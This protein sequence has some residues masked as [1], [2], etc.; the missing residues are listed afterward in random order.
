MQSSN[1]QPTKS[2]LEYAQQM[3]NTL[4]DK[5]QSGLLELHIKFDVEES[6][7]LVVN[8]FSD[9]GD[10]SILLVPAGVHEVD[11]SNLL[12]VNHIIGLNTD[13]SDF[14]V[15]KIIAND[16]D[17][18]NFD[19]GQTVELA[20]ADTQCVHANIRLEAD[21]NTVLE[22]T[23]FEDKQFSD[24]FFNVQLA[25]NVDILNIYTGV[26]YH[27]RDWA[28]NA[29]GH[30]YRGRNSLEKTLDNA[31]QGVLNAIDNTFRPLMKIGEMLDKALSK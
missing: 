26:L 8:D 7:V 20:T 18:V 16:E 21:R 17:V 14:A 31:H 11:Y 28:T 29:Y 13:S 23:F 15:L 9:V 6:P 1:R 25:H 24:V 27:G 4:G 19:T 5:T 30:D 12:N 10:A 3:L 2:E 22:T